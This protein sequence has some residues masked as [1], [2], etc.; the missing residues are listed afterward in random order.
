MEKDFFSF[1]RD[2]FQA[3][4]DYNTKVGKLCDAYIKNI[5]SA[6]KNSISNSNNKT[7]LRK[8]KG[9]QKFKKFILDE[10]EQSE[11]G[12]MKKSEL[13]AHVDRKWEEL[14]E[15]ER[16]KW[17]GMAAKDARDAKE[18]KKNETGSGNKK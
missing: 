9:Y 6:D 18:Q 1:L 16:K 14:A 8:T 13:N 4:A 11:S 17:D 3:N 12:A 2:F 10:L 5:G 15:T 7:K